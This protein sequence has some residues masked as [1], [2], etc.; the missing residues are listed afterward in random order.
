[1]LKYST[2]E[3]P[4]V[5]ENYKYLGIISQEKLT[6]DVILELITEPE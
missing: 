5:D 6:S 3:L 2:D 4:V 1:M